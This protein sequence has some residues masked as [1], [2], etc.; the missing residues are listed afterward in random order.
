MVVPTSASSE[1]ATTA[2]TPA[3]APT[4]TDTS[5]RGRR[6]GGVDPDERRARRRSALVAGGLE[7]FGTEGYARASVKSICEQAGLTQRYFY[8]SF[9]DRAD[10]LVAVY[11]DCVRHARTATLAAAA[12]FLDGEADLGD[13]E[14]GIEPTR[15]P[16]AARATLGAFMH[17]LA[18]DSRRARVMLVEVVGVSP[19]IERVRMRAIHDWADLV[20]TLARGNRPPTSKQRL[21]SV[22]LVGAVTQ[23]M[24]DWYVAGQGE[25][26]I[27]REPLDDVLDV[28]VEL[29][30]AAHGRL[31]T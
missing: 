25:S 28:C 6:Y 9:S 16:E 15:I 3:S 22:G 24:V 4:P 19:E 18:D 30:V 2:S 21:A 5:S 27:A 23:L 14:A 17:A 26:D 29:F 8:E 13:V 1:T 12:E 10:L 11:D 31:L 7:V 20:L